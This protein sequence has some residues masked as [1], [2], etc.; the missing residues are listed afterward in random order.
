[1]ISR[2]WESGGFTIV[3]L[4]VAMSISAI[5][6]LSGYEL[7]QA[8]KTAGDGQSADLA[9]T[10]GIVHGLDRIRD[11]LLHALPRPGSHE[12]IF[13]GS[14]PALE[15]GAQTAQLLEFHSLCAG[16]GDGR[17]R[18]LRQVHQVRYELT[19]TKDSL[20]LYRRAAPVVVA[21]LASGDEGRELILDHVEQIQIAFPNGRT[22]ESSF[23]SK[24]KLPVGVE[25]TV[26]TC[27]QIWPL[28]V[29]LPCGSL[30]K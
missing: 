8:L 6:L 30:E 22:S 28:S 9:A 23:S 14:N 18:G 25:L 4:I 29:K 17:L 24:E 19:R 7:F 15:G 5:T 2:D 13:V 10:A 3:E 26:M 1:M 12:P 16:Y 27:G 20:C 21:G 11:D